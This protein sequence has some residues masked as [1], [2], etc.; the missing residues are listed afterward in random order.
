M[1]LYE[2]KIQNIKYQPNKKNGGNAPPIKDLRLNTIK[3]PCGW[4]AECRKKLANDWRIRLTEEIKDDKRAIFVT[5]SFSPESISKIETEIY[6]KKWRGYETTDGAIYLDV[7]DLAAY[8]VRMWSERWRKYEKKAPKHFL[9]TEL[10]HKNSERIHLH[11]LIW[12][13]RNMIEKT[14]KYGNTYL[15][16]WV[17]ERTVNYIVKYITK[18]DETHK[19]YKQRT[20]TSKKM[21]INYINKHKNNHKYQEEKT[22]TYY[23]TSN[24]G[25]LGLPRYYKEKLWTEEEREKLWLYELD[26]NQIKIGK[27]TYDKNKYT[28]DELKEKIKTERRNSER[29]G[30]GTPMNNGIKWI[31]TE[32]MKK[33]GKINK[34]KSLQKIEKRYTLEEWTSEENGDKTSEVKQKKLGQY[35]NNTTDAQR[36]YNELLIEADSKGVSVRILRLMK[37]GIIDEN[38]IDK[39]VDK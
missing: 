34:I 20:F 18:V 5:L 21:G 7:N 10:G 33:K 12:G 36:K 32:E 23:K 1:C 38:F 8:A 24:G 28:D 15:G 30:Y 27:E 26:K 19:G 29:A 9:V 37:E 13:E 14:W 16:E 11:G 2:K 31:I 4:C 3:A 25:K 17:D 39:Y 35:I 6:T 22:R